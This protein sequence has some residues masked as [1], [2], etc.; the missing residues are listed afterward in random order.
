MKAMNSPMPS[1]MA[2]LSGSGMACMTASRRPVSTRTVIAS[3]STTTTPIASGQVSP[4]PPTSWNA[5]TALRPRPAA[6]ANGYLATSPI[7]M[8]ARP[9]ARAVAVSTGAKGSLAPRAS[10]TAPRTLG[11]T[12][13]M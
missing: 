12:N 2:C 9:A 5:T 13:R 8:L 6:M 11:L 4:A 1:P 10:A 3:P 7:A